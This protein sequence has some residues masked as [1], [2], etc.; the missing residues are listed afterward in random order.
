MREAHE[1]CVKANP[2]NAEK[3]KDVLEHLADSA[4]RAK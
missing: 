2:D 4:R 3:F 1:A